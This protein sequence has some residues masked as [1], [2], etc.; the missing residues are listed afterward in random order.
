MYALS[1][2]FS[3][4]S[5]MSSLVVITVNVRVELLTVFFFIFLLMRLKN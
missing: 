5:V 4:W 3:S 1:S 2:K